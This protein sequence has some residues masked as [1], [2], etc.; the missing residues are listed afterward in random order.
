MNLTQELVNTCSC[1]SD[2]TK[3]MGKS[4]HS[5]ITKELKKQLDESKISY[6]H[7]TKNGSRKFEKIEKKCPICSNMFFVG[8]KEQTTCS[9][10]CSNT[11]F[12]KKRNRPDK[13]KNYRTICFANHI[14]K[15]VVCDE[16]NIVEVHHMD[17]NKKNNSP[18]NLIP[19]CPTHH[20][21]WHSRFRET[22]RKKVE[23]YIDNL[24]IKI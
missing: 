23:S 14:K 16:K 4:P 21:Y 3:K 24:K 6:S 12:A 2:L 10:S 20:Q 1:F 7:F 22:I 18:E 9:H 8:K 19:L 15:C 13:Y 11:F 17:E 5:R